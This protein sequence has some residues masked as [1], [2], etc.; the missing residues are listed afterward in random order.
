MYKLTT[1]KDKK[2]ALVDMLTEQNT[3]FSN[4]TEKTIIKYKK[5]W[6]KI[7]FIA[8]KK[9]YNTSHL[10][11]D[12]WYIPKCHN[13]D[14]PIWK[15]VSPTSNDYIY[16]CPICKRIYDS[17]IP[18][19]NCWGSNIKEVWLGAHKLK[20][21]LQKKFNI[22]PLV[23]E[24]TDINRVTKI[25]KVKEKL[26]NTQFVVSTPIFSFPCNDFV[27]DIIIFINADWW[28]TIPDFNTNEKHFLFLYEFI[29]NYP[30]KNF[31]IQTFNFEHYVY[32]YLVNLDLEGFW[33][34]ELSFRK[35]F[36]YPP[37]T[38]IAVLIY[39]N[40][41]EEKVYSKISKIEAELKYLVEKLNP[42][43]EIYPTPQLIFKRFWKYHYNIIL[44]WENL[45]PFLD[46]AV[47]SLK[48]R[49]KHFQIDW[50]PTNLI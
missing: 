50:L 8:N 26:Q 43:V 38:E 35:Q 2:I 48:L 31:I 24:N 13:C 15:Y 18:C 7:L 36:N 40:Q 1:T 4:V 46:K 23:I 28:L 14:I 11:T 21:Y 16:M 20:E 12:C 27:P 33:K 10:C 3:V 37:Y 32:K 34:Q 22:K 49:E 6:K 42:T 29:N 30:T 17:L 39:K 9:W 44:K 19:S 5:L 47:Q 25:K 41:I 45:K